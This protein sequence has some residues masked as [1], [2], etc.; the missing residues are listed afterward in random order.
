MGTISNFIEIR[1]DGKIIPEGMT[2]DQWEELGWA[3]EKVIRIRWDY[4]GRPVELEDSGGM[5]AEIIDS[6]TAIAIE[7]NGGQNL[8]V[9]D[10]NGKLRCRV[11]NVQNISGKDLSGV[12]AWFGKVEIDIAHCFAVVFEVGPAS[13]DSPSDFYLLHVD[14]LNG[15]LLKWQRTR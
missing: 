5:L 12:F 3:P 1:R 10:P 13:W 2:Y 6:R 11:P 15:K 7:I 14:S 9:Y 8:S 4:E